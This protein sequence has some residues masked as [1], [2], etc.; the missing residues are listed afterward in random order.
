MLA[1]KVIAWVRDVR[2]DKAQASFGPDHPEVARDLNNL[3]QLYQATNRLKEAEPLYTRALEIFETS[4]GRDHPSTFTV[5]L[6]RA[7]C[8]QKMSGE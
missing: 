4:L 3:A 5:R 1:L 2:Q 8:R 6:N 7:L